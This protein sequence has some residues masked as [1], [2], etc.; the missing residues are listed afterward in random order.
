MTAFRWGMVF[1]AGLPVL[2]FALVHVLATRWLHAERPPF[3]AQVV[4]DGGDV[5]R[6]GGVRLLVADKGAA[7]QQVCS[8]ACDDLEFRA[9]DVGDDVFHVSVLDQA[10]HCIACDQGQYVSNGYGAPIVRW[11]VAGQPLRIDIRRANSP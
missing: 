9:E 5:T 6:A 10:G 4:I 3:Y 2:V 8:D 7:V 11:R 1:G